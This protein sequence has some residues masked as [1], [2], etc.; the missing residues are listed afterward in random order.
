MHFNYLDQAVCIHLRLFVHIYHVQN[1]S[2]VKRRKTSLDMQLSMMRI[3]PTKNT[4]LPKYLYYCQIFETH[5]HFNF[6]KK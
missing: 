3:K 4:F 2:V 6:E 1:S 5:L